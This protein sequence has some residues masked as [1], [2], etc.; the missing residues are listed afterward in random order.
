MN[1]A[2]SSKG[3]GI[4]V[5][6]P[7]LALTPRPSP[8]DGRSQK[9]IVAAKT[10]KRGQ[11]SSRPGQLSRKELKRRAEDMQQVFEQ[12]RSSAE[13]VDDQ[14]EITETPT[15]I[16]DNMLQRIIVFAGIHGSHGHDLLLK[17]PLHSLVADNSQ[18]L[19]NQSLPPG[20]PCV[21]F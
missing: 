18:T 16:S 5:A 10:N 14:D 6:R 3:K 9:S 20:N 11:V 8:R 12:R 19:Q 17:S 21:P 2:L 4:A 1:V 13:N 7:S 15:E